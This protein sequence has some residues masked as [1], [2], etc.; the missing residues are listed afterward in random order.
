MPDNERV[1]KANQRYDHGYFRTCLVMIRSFIQYRELVWQ[2][3]RRDLL[4]NYKKSYFG[5]AWIVLTPLMG[6]V[7]WVF[8][9][10]T[11]LLRPGVQGIPYPAYL[12]IGASMW[13]L[14]MG[15]YKSS[16]QTLTAARSLVMQV[17]FPREVFLFEKILLQLTNFGVALLLNLLVILLFGVIPSRGIFLLPLVV[18]P[19]I[20][21]A[22]AIGLL[23]SMIAIVAENFSKLIH[24]FIGLTFWITPILYSDKLDKSWAQI[25]VHWNPLTYLVCSAR[26]VIIYGR[27]YGST[28]YWICAA[29]S[30]ILFVFSWRA[31]YISEPKI[32]ERMI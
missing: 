25:L 7:S 26:D 5:A 2:L 24:T 1:Y 23:V 29:L 21:F 12:L 31:F 3:Y 16:S 8:M 32:L 28:G 22:S 9:H 30:F 20:F 13:G 15:C 4:A 18:L 10:Q 14:F 19:M 6:I 17:S 27:L 11:G